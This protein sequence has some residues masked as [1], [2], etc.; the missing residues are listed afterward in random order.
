[1]GVRVVMFWGFFVQLISRFHADS[2][3]VGGF[4]GIVNF[5]RLCE[6]QPRLAVFSASLGSHPHAD[7]Q[8]V[9]VVV[10]VV[11]VVVVVVVVIVV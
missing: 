8:L 5:L 7:F 1:M 6:F 3:G 4:F 9:V 10:I 2:S 11:V